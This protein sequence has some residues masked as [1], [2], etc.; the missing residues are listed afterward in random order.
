MESGT[1]TLCTTHTECEAM[2]EVAEREMLGANMP[3]RP[4]KNL[5]HGLVPLPELVV[6]PEH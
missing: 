2:E 5:W 1:R 4:E 3:S 6:G